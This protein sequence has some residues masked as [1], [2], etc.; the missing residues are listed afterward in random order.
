MDAKQNDFTALDAQ[1]AES[2][3][4]KFTPEEHAE[5]QENIDAFRKGMENEIDSILDS[6]K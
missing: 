1:T 3:F 2:A 6:M 5:A 4:A